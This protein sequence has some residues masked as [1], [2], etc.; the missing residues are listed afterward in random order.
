MFYCILIH[1]LFLYS[2]YCCI[3][4]DSKSQWQ[5]TTNID[6]LTASVIQKSRC[7]LA[8]HVQLRFSYEAVAEVLA[9]A[10][11]L[12][13]LG[14]G[15][16]HFQAHS[17]GCWPEISFSCHMG[18]SIHWLIVL[19]AEQLDSPRASGPRGRQRAHGT[20]VTHPLQPHF[21][22]DIPPHSWYSSLET[23]QEI[24]PTLK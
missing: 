4:N 22:N 3:T 24:Q 1:D 18:F 15:R 2:S 14:Q 20:K 17:C 10:A 19:V 6:Y 12:L 16:T 8:R 21:G 11:V 9:G 7:G 23:S 5:R 13:G